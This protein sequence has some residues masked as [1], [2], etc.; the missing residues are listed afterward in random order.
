[1]PKEAGSIGQPPRAE[2][3]GGCDTPNMGTKEIKLSSPEK[4]LCILNS[5][6]ISAAPFYVHI[7]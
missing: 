4:A 6:A 7:S 1:M 5:G 3:T 2:V